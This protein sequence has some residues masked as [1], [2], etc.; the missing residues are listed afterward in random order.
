MAAMICV[1]DARSIDRRRARSEM[2]LSQTLA[3]V[4]EADRRRETER[5]TRDWRLRHPEAD[6]VS[7]ATAGIPGE[8]TIRDPRAAGARPGPASRGSACEPA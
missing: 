5:R 2:F 8:G 3:E 6:E 4:I 1:T 7:A